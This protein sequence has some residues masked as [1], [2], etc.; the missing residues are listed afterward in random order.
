M[1][2]YYVIVAYRYL[3]RQWGYSLI[4]VIGLSFGLAC[5]LLIALYVL[6]ELRFDSFHQQADRIY[7]VIEKKTSTDAK[8]SQTAT[9][10][11]N[12][13][14]GAQQHFP[15][16]QNTV[17]LMV[18]GRAGV[19]TED[20]QNAIYEDYW[21]T[22][23][24]F[25][26]VFD[27]PLLEG[28]RKT[29]LTAPHSVILTRETAK[30][31]FGDQPALGKLIQS[32]RQ[33]T[34][35]KV[36]GILQNFPANSHLRFNLL[37]SEATY[38]SN[39]PFQQFVT[40]DWSS[41]NFAT[42]VQLKSQATAGEVATKISELVAE[43]RTK[44]QPASTFSL[45]PLRDVHFYSKGIEGSLGQPGDIFYVY[46]FSAIALFVLFI[47][48]INYMNLATARTAIRTKE[49][50]VRKVAG[51]GQS[52]LIAQ[53]LTEAL[54]IA[55]V[56]LAFAVLFVRF[57]LPYFN[58][59]TEKNL[60]LD[61]TTDYRIWL[62]VMV[63]T[64]LVGLLSGSYPAFL[65]SRFRPQAL[66]KNLRNTQRGSFQLRRAL[67]VFQF[68]LSIVMMIATLLVYLQLQYVR[69]KNLGFNQDQL[70][71]VDINSGK[72][73]RGFETIRSEYAKLPGVK[74]VAVS[75]RVPGEWKDLPQVKVKS[76]GS[77]LN[78]G[79][80]AYFLG[81]DEGFL[82]TFEVP[83][84]KGR[85]FNPSSL[86]DSTGLLLNESAAKVLGI[87]EASGQVLEIPAV[88]FQGQSEPLQQPFQARVIGIT[89][90]FHFQSLREKIAPMVMAYRNNPIQSIDYFTIRLSGN[91]IPATLT[92]ME[93]VLQQI[94][95]A[96]L[97]EYHF[98]NEQLDLFYREDLRREKIFIAAALSTIFIAC[99]GLFGLA[100][101]TAQQRTR[102]I[103]I[104]K[105]L[106]ASVPQLVALL[107]KD[108]VKLVLIANVIAWPLAWWAMHRWLQDFAYR[109]N[110]GWWAFALVGA[111]AL[112]IA[113]I[114]VSSQAIKAALA[115]PVKSLRTE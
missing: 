88:L 90:D 64:G 104:R 72:V 92:Q 42:Y 2:K 105:V 20:N 65:L 85:N 21:V 61:T 107:S 75:S 11:F 54:L 27:F 35:F 82:S 6:D 8:E 53:F 23:Q 84:L 68:T 71:V 14:A 109:I 95:A 80:D 91:Q 15:E 49:I 30:R 114:T 7:R 77:G 67:V 87:T 24:S 28:D 26:D 32:E 12:V 98:L 25:L 93:T 86:A 46:V 37:F 73:R 111:I 44:D 22:G 63:L 60:A 5:F 113:L 115:N 40:Q 99:L 102:E 48:C 1:I 34:P 76:P 39:E 101:F 70:V 96:H 52:N 29:A 94:D 47:A 41:N 58:A 3:V 16:V 38:A 66:L 59:F 19:T 9:V 51:A 108:F 50:G 81:I 33:E 56:S 62:G 100:A 110:I 78:E 45:Q 17:R 97:F 31:L 4:N 69:T 79:A 112:F 57:L 83:L 10:A 89:L 55:F 18:M 13:S 36:T 106:G 43:H 74:S 103:G